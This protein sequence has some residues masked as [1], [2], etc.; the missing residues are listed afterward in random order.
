[1]D[2]PLSCN[3]KT[4]FL[5]ATVRLELKDEKNVSP[6]EIFVRFTAPWKQGLQ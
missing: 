4:A 5:Q 3:R 6:M 2:V 1:M